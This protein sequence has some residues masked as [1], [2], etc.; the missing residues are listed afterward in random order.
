MFEC[1]RCTYDTIRM[2]SVHFH[3]IRLPDTLIARQYQIIGITNKFV[4]KNVQNFNQTLYYIALCYLQIDIRF[5]IIQLII[6]THLADSY[7]TF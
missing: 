7:K 5:K 6:T 4:S 3:D 2:G 1:L